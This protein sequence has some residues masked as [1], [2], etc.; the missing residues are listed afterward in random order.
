M[1]FDRGGKEWSKKFYPSVI[2]SDERMTYTSVRKILVD[3]DS[4][5]RERYGSLL[6]DFELM[7]ELCGFSGR[8]DLN[9][10]P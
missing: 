4:H 7:N 5:E 3:D 9:G 1:E 10:K 6:R 2:M 8:G